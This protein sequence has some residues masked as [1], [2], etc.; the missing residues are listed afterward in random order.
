MFG[1]NRFCYV[2]VIVRLLYYFCM[3]LKKLFLLII[4]DMQIIIEVLKGF[5]RGI[6]YYREN[7]ECGVRIGMVGFVEEC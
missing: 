2:D 1:L 7:I 5:G 6:E 3:F 4:E